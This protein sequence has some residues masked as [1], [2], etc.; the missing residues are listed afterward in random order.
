MSIRILVTGGTIDGL[1]YDSLEEGPESHTS[2]I[3]D[4]LRQA[5]VSVENSV[6]VLMSK[7]SRFITDEDRER[8]L[9][10]C[11]ECQ[12]SRIIITHGTLTMSETARFLGEKSVQKTIVLFGSAIPANE[13]KSDASFNLGAAIAAVQLLPAGAYITM[14]GRIFPYDDVKKNLGTGYFERERKTIGHTIPEACFGRPA[15]EGAPMGQVGR[16][17]RS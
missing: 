4:L 15:D 13:Q 6:E 2:R 7:D 5:R 14:N 1:D 11:K 17:E 16:R 3:P 12:E 8:M 10:R 9:K